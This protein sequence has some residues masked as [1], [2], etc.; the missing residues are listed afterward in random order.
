MRATALEDSPEVT[1]DDYSSRAYNTKERVCSFWHQVDET[2]ELGASTVLEVGPGAGFV[3]NWLRVGWA[4][5]KD[6]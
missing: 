3:T 5:R 1:S 2:F 6:A 4:R